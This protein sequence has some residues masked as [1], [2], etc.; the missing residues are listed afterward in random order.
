MYG[1]TAMKDPLLLMYANSK[2]QQNYFL[3]RIYLSLTY[4]IDSD[5]QIYVSGIE[6]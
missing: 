4:C 3:E 6:L 1:I 2:L 5:C